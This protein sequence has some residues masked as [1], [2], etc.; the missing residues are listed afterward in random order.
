MPDNYFITVHQAFFV[1]RDYYI[2]FSDT[3]YYDIEQINNLK[4]NLCIPIFCFK[5][6]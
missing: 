1:C 4:F 6:S 3:P 5:V 2:F